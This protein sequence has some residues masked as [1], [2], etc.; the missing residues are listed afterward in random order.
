M[1]DVNAWF[2]P[3]MEQEDIDALLAAYPGDPHRAAADAWDDYAAGLDATV[4]SAEVTAVST[5]AQSISYAAGSSP[6]SVAQGRADWHRQRANVRSVKMGSK[7]RLLEYADVRDEVADLLLSDQDE[8][9]A[10]TIVT[11][12]YPPIGG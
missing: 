1:A 5:G 2:P 9:D 4:A 3:G 10:G 11:A 7:Y 6:F 8:E 12:D